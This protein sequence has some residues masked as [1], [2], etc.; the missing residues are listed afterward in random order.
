MSTTAVISWM[1]ELGF[2][3]NLRSA[4]IN[5]RAAAAAERHEAR[6]FTPPLLIVQRGRDIG[7]M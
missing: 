1:R 6:V 4:F 2:F 5:A 3:T 7:Y